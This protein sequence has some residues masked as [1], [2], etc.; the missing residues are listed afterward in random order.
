MTQ[1]TVMRRSRTYPVGVDEAFDEVMPMPLEL[2]FSR[3][4]GPLPGIKGVTG[5]DA[6][7]RTTGQT[8]TIHLADGGTLREELVEVRRPDVFAYRLTDVTG[9]LRPLASSIDGRWEFEPAGTGVRIAWQWSIHPA[10][11]AGALLLPTFAR[12][13]QGFARQAL[14]GLEDV[15]VA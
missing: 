3:R 4:Y 11:R 6:P 12:L 2:L 9:P 1:P 13:W 7:W 5:Q 8:R 15:L 10:N 14:D